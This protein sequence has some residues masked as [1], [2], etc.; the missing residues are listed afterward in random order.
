[1]LLPARTNGAGNASLTA[2]AGRSALVLETGTH[3]VLKRIFFSEGSKRL[4]FPAYGDAFA[5]SE[6]ARD[7]LMQRKE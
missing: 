4:L 3:A 7:W 6:E 1:L 5:S 2:K